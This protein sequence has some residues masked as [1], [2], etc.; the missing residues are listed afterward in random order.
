MRPEQ[1]ALE[2]RLRR[3]ANKLGLYVTK[4]RSEY[5]AFGHP[6]GYHIIRQAFNDIL[7]GSCDDEVFLKDFGK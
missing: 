4:S 1:K 2:V 6:R 3:R 7:V 5:D